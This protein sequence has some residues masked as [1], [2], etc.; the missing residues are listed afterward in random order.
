[1][2]SMGCHG[3]Y[4]VDGSWGVGGLYGLIGSRGVASP[5]GVAYGCG[6]S[7]KGAWPTDQAQSAEWAVSVGG[8]GL[9]VGVAHRGVVNGGRGFLMGGRGLWGLSM[10]GVANGWAWPTGVSIGWV[11]L[12]DGRGL[13]GGCLWWVWLMG[14]RGLWGLPMGG[15]G[16]RGCL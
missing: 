9:W 1:M 16:Y 12:M 5:E 15:R 13:W 14:G 8:R 2:G 7:R 4:G 11:W 6:R 10:A 3:V